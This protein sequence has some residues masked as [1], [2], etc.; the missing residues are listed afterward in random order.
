MVAKPTAA[1]GDITV[2]AINFETIDLP[3]KKQS[4]QQVDELMRELHHPTQILPH[5]GN[6]E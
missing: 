3:E 1:V 4:E 6:N 5:P 2:F